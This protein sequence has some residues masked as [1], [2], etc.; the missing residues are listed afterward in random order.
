MTKVLVTGGAGF[1]GYHL[2]KRLLKKGYQVDLLDNLARGVVDSDLNHLMSD[3]GVRFINRDLAQAQ[4]LDDLAD[5]YHY[6][7]H[8]AGIVGV[9][10]VLKR[11]LDVLRNNG[12]MTLNAISFAQRQKNL[13]R[14]LFAST[15][16]VYAGTLERFTL[17]IPTDEFAPLTL[18]E[19]SHPRTS[20]M[21]SKIHGEALCQYADIPFTIFRP[22]NL[23]GPRMGM[24]HVIPELLYKAHQSA[25]GCGI[26]VF[27][28]EHRRTFCY[29]SD[30][31]E[32][33]AR[34][35]E[36][37]NCARQTLN[38]GN[39]APEITIG[40]LAEIILRTVGKD[41]KILAKPATP[42]SPMRRCPDMTR[43]LALSKHVS[44]VELKVGIERT[45]EW[46][47]TAVFSKREISAN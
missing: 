9:G 40:Q 21:L 13:Q 17:P 18:T 25:N 19:L 32:M 28:V 4:S 3:P 41:L 10:H 5:D 26:E 16:E 24:A 35:A 14:L 7:Y 44:E 30:A 11:P 20:Y 42:G 39:Q 45:Y 6:V 33:M 8:F 12:L 43:T 31:V 36:A 2:A 34:A 27:S 29:V 47:K 22:H 15:S 37:E 46:Y 38:I 1:V 23:Y